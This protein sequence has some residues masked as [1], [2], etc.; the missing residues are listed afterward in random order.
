MIRH[1]I[2]LVMIAL[3]LAAP[4]S[5]LAMGAF[6]PTV[7]QQMTQTDTANQDAVQQQLAQQAQ[8]KQQQQWLQLQDQLSGISTIQQDVT[9]NKAKTADQMFNQWDTY[10]RQ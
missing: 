9:V 6:D 5:V 2:L 7:L 4:S 3:C 10:I 8:A 1:C